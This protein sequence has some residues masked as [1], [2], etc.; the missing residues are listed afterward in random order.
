[1]SPKRKPSPFDRLA[2]LQK[3]G[4]LA[5]VLPPLPA[6]AAPAAPAPPVTPESEADALRRAMAGVKPL[7]AREARVARAPAAKP[8]VPLPAPAGSDDELLAR[9]FAG[10]KP[11]DDKERARRAA[12][13]V[14]G[15]TARDG[16]RRARDAA[17]AEARRAA[18]AGGD[19]GAAA[20]A[21]ARRAAATA[22]NAAPPPA[23]RETLLQ[24]TD[25]ATAVAPGVDARTLRHL[26]SG[27]DLGVP[28]PERAVV[29][30]HGLRAAEVDAALRR[31]VARAREAA[32]RHLLVVT[33]RGLGSEGGVPVVRGAAVESLR[34]HPEVLAFTPAQP[35]HGGPGA[36]YVFL[37]KP[38][39]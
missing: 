28:P 37:R 2:E 17:A 13:G 7:G 3:E 15:D 9:A 29:D 16:D 31:A 39:A 33:G 10:V 27:E 30:L 32:L 35:R 24:M 38:R 4:K 25:D 1:V 36:L 14:S 19:A 20:L 11:L 18:A 8:A 34:R 12:A 6:K 21:E 23:T 26:R 5:A 22:A